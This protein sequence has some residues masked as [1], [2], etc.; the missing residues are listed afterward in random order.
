MDIWPVVTPL[1]SSRTARLSSLPVVPPRTPPEVPRYIT[2]TP[3]SATHRSNSFLSTSSLPS[4]SSTS[5][6]LARTS[7]PTSSPMPP[8]RL[9][10]RS[11]TASTRPS[12]LAVVVSLSL[13]TTAACA[14][15]LLPPTATSLTTSRSTGTLSRRAR[16]TSLVATTLLSAC[17]LSWLWPRRL[18]RRTRYDLPKV[19]ENTG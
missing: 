10:L 4:P 19:S 17:P 1:Q 6:V 8:R 15:T 18:P 2:Q 3:T 7:T 12:P 14:P 5:A 13:A 9:A 11:A 16:H